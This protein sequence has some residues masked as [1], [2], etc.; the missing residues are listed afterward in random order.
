MHP[1]AIE[2]VPRAVLFDLDDTLCDYAGARAGRLRIAFA[3]ALGSARRA[4]AAPVDLDRLI[5]ESI[6]IHPHGVDHFGTLLGRYG[7]DD[8]EAVGAAADWYRRNRFHG[9][10]LFSDA[11]YVVRAVRRLVIGG[12]DASERPIGVVTNGPSEVQRA[13]IELLGVGELVDFAI[14]SGEFGVEKPDP[15]I[16]REALRQAGVAPG[17]ALFVGDSLQFDIVGAARSGIPS[18]WVNPRGERPP[19]GAPRP[20]RELSS[21]GELPTLLDQEFVASKG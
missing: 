8:A 11:A 10:E 9:L 17:E 19:R 18:V 20:T 2:R 14:V 6:A 15:A 1:P 3:L 16:F 4:G 21:L 7:V 12:A 5:A 13:K